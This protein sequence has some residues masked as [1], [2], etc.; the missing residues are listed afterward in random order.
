MRSWRNAWQLILAKRTIFDDKANE[1]VAQAITLGK[2]E[3]ELDSNRGNAGVWCA[4]SLTMRFGPSRAMLKRSLY[5][6]WGIDWPLLSER[7]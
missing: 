7:R 5:L 6:K 3:R 4:Y 2:Q 1:L